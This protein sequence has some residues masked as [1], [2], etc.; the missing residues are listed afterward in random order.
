MSA[1]TDSRWSAKAQDDAGQTKSGV[2]NCH[3]VKVSSGVNL[4][5]GL[6]LKE[7]FSSPTEINC[8]HPGQLYNGWLE[9]TG[10]KWE[11]VGFL[12]FKLNYSDNSFPF[13]ESA[14]GLGASIIFRCQPGMLLFGHSSTVCQI[15]GKWRYA[16]PQCLAPCVLP[17]ISQG[18]VVPIEGEFDYNT[19]TLA[20]PGAGSLSKVQ[21][22]TTLEIVCDEHYEFPLAS[23]TPPTCNNGTWSIIPR[24]VPARWD[25]GEL[26]SRR[27]RK[28]SICNYIY[29]P[30]RCKTMPKVPKNGMVLA[31]KTEHG[32]KARFKCKDGFNLT[33]PG[34]KEITDPNEFVLTCSFGN[35]TGHIPFCQEVYCS[36]PGY[37]PNGK[38]FLVGNMGLYDYRPY[39]RK[40]RETLELW[41]SR[42]LI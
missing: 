25:I 3:H 17:T 26:S 6:L 35:W 32:M 37:I 8:G 9:M 36:F 2:D 22:G 4:S 5:E 34:G 28:D 39:V 41:K 18:I 31:P 23:L 33:A 20:P 29:V 27:I 13:P 40:V 21:H 12:R 38:V 15:D 19:T 16:V 24:C 10:E 11:L 1:N 42:N 7:L 30:F 14:Y